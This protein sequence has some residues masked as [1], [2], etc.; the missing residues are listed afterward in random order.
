MLISSLDM[1]D[2]LP[3]F[4]LLLANSPS[5]ALSRMPTMRRRMGVWIVLVVNQNIHNA[6]P[7]PVNMR[8]SFEGPFFVI[9]LPAFY[10]GCDRVVA[11]T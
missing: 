3:G 1:F 5:P 11:W 4:L 6:N 9:V 10:G 8:N 2:Y 7:M